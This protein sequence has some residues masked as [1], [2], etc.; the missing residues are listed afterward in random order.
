[1]QFQTQYCQQVRTEKFC[2]SADLP[3]VPL[4]GAFKASLLN[5]GTKLFSRK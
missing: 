1:M 4:K 3:Y 5:H 2:V